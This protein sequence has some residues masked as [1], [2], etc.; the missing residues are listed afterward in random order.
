M[1]ATRGR[2]WRPGQHYDASGM[3]RSLT[4]C[5]D[6]C[7]ALAVVRHE[8]ASP[9]PSFANGLPANEAERRAPRVSMI[10]DHGVVTRV[11]KEAAHAAG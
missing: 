3:D 7:G 5:P 4:I 1:R 9:S 8:P 6:L 11:I 2:G 10:S